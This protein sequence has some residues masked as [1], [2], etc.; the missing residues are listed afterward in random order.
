VS[1]VAWIV[2]VLVLTDRRRSSKPRR[3]TADS[4]A[5]QPGAGLRA[6]Q[7]AAAL[8]LVHLDAHDVPFLP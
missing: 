5:G 1:A 3:T 4:F 7:G 2:V 8:G 6:S